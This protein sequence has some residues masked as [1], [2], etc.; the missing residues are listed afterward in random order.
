MLLKQ[1]YE[2]KKQ[3]KEIDFY[4]GISLSKTNSINEAGP[5]LINS[6]NKGVSNKDVIY[7]LAQFYYD[8]QNYELAL[9]NIEKSLT[10]ISTDYKLYW[11]KAKIHFKLNNFDKSFQNFDEAIKLNPDDRDLLIDKIEYLEKNNKIS[12][13][14]NGYS[15][16]I[17]SSKQTDGLLYLKRALL[18]KKTKNIEYALKDFLEA[19]KLGLNVEKE[20]EE[21]N[22]IILLQKDKQSQSQEV[23]R[24]QKQNQTQ[25]EESKQQINNEVKNIRDGV[26]EENVKIDTKVSAIYLARANINFKN[27]KYDVALSDITEAIKCNPKDMQ[28]YLLRAK[29]YVQLKNE[30]VAIQDLL[31]A[32]ELFPQSVVPYIEIADIYRLKNNFVES[33]SYYKKAI[34]INSRNAIAYFGY[35]ML[36]EQNGKKDMAIQNYQEASK[37]DIKLSK[38]CGARIKKLKS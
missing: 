36:C 28:E 38:E 8:K 7:F 2:Y 18:Y 6:I 31:K 5:Y 10:L 26:K 35:A 12:E 23:E 33:E 27:N 14:I 4:F 20:I 29:I 1:I 13:C 11:L 24:I 30:D 15:T 16:I 19:K 17:S 22:N 34:Q 25:K 21:I 37:I 32:I 3:E 9:E